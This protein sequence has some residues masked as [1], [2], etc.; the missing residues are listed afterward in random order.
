MSRQVD[1]GAVTLAE[2]PRGREAEGDRPTVTVVIPV[3]FAEATIGRLVHAL[4]EALGPRYGLQVVLVSEIEDVGDDEVFSIR[5]VAGDFGDLCDAAAAAG[6]A[7][8]VYDDVDGGGDLALDRDD[9]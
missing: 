3:Y 1:S 7:V 4:L 8:D 6:Q 2:A 9:G 5:V